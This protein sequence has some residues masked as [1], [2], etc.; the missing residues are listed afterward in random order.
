MKI[1][2]FI[3]LICIALLLCVS[4][5]SK[6]RS[7][8]R[9]VIL[10][11]GN[12]NE[13][14]NQFLTEDIKYFKKELPRLH[15]NL[16]SVITKNEFNDQTDKLISQIGQ[17]SNEQVFT[18]LNK[19][20]ASVGDAHTNINYWDGFHYPLQFYL[21]NG[22]VY[23]V[24]TDTSLEEMMFSKVIKIDGVDIDEITGKLKKLISHE[25]DSW[26]LARLPEYLQSPVY[27]YGLGII[28]DESKAAFTV[29]K[30]G[31]VQEF[32]ISAL[33]YEEKADF[34]NNN[35]K[36]VITGY[37]DKYYDYHFLADNKALYFEY[38]VCADMADL[39]FTDFNQKMFD[40]MENNKVERVV[41]DLRNNSGGNSE[42]LNPFTD[43]LKSYIKEHG[44]VKTYIL[45][46]RETF[47]SGMIAIYRIKE[48]VSDAVAIGEPTGGALDCYGDIKTF[49]L[50]NSQLPISYSTKYFELSKSFTYKNNGVGT[51]LPDITI[52]Q[53][54]EAYKNGTDEMLEYA[55]S[56]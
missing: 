32:T 36:D 40:A 20:I 8:N 13:E 46:G 54:I 3:L 10:K 35:T 53:T 4:A 21:F 5:C 43:R 37:Y 50:P 31:K 7:L 34:V 26:V 33:N 19:I 49:N 48:S 16:F 41:I 22:E 29:E 2:R 1:K 47:S 9:D 30:Q 52:E 42:I 27:M 23:I 15:K 14:R 25:N 45:V 28:K 56:N 12:T 55:L 51:F 39:K 44:N 6:D 18:E 38:N 24:N 11:N 17:L